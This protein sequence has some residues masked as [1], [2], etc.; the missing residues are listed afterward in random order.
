MMLEDLFAPANRMTT[1]LCIAALVLAVL[2]QYWLRLSVG[3]AWLRR[4]PMLLCGGAAAAFLVL[5]L[6]M[7]S[8]N[9][10][11]AVSWLFAMLLALLLLIACAIG[12]L[13][14]RHKQQKDQKK[15]PDNR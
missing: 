13:L 11:Q 1:L 10:W 7:L 5:F 3:N 6:V 9:G 4:L 14:A 8:S 15:T 2:L 12:S